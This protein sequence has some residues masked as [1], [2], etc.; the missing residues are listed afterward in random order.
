[1][2][3]C[4]VR[5]FVDTNR[6]LL[7][8][9]GATM[10][11]VCLTLGLVM[12]KPAPDQFLNGARILAAD[13]K[14]T[15][16]VP[17][18]KQWL[19]GPPAGA[20]RSGSYRDTFENAADTAI[21]SLP[22]GTPLQAPENAPSPKQF[23]VPCPLRPFVFCPPRL[24]PSPHPASENASDT[25][26]GSLPVRTPLQPPEKASSPKQW[27]VGPPAGTFRPGSFRG[28]IEN[29]PDTAIG[30]LPL[31]TPP[32]GPENATSPKQWLVKPPA[33]TSQPGSFR[34]TIENA[35]P[36]GTPLQGPENAPSP[37]QHSALPPSGTLPPRSRTVNTL[38][39]CNFSPNK[40]YMVATQAA[41]QDGYIWR[42]GGGWVWSGQP[43][44]CM[45]A[46]NFRQRTAE[47]AVI[48]CTFIYESDRRNEIPCIGQEFVYSSTSD[49]AGYYQCNGNPTRCVST[50]YCQGRTC[51]QGPSGFR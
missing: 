28:T 43:C 15:E 42:Q 44:S 8:K 14:T 30:S 13:D 39:T 10:M 11:A 51:T 3:G 26:V 16:A 21:G 48:R 27:L 25:A 29:A 34:D 6:K 2:F 12:S 24:S 32:Q 20:S 50:G 38:C 45:P 4:G 23:L 31:G 1:M 22:L 19:V 35:S 47:N 18:P 37:K 40:L 36:L 41:K 5:E 7:C 46:S 9:T 17:N 33:G 49:V